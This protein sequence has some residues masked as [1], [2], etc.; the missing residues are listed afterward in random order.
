MLVSFFTYFITFSMLTQVYYLLH[1][2]DHEDDD[3]AGV[4]DENGDDVDQRVALHLTTLLAGE[5]RCISGQKENNLKINKQKF[6]LFL[7]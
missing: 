4:E 3:S 7:F 1:V 5:R 6:I 2:V